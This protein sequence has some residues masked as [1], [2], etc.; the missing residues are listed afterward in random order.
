MASILIVDDAVDACEPLQKFLERAGHTVACVPNG[1]DALAAVIAHP[2]DA[3]VLDLLMPE[4]DGPSFLEICRSYLR[5]QHLPVVVLTAITDGPLIDRVRN[6]KVGDIL[7]KG[8]A[9]HQDIL[10]AV[11]AQIPRLPA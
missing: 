4:M 3:V 7:V 8:K 6:A 11:I 5:L 10:D 1:R 2:P 9:T